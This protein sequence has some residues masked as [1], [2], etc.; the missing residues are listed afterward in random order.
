MNS[1]PPT[2][3]LA[4]PGSIPVVRHARYSA[5][6][7]CGPTLFSLPAPLF[8]FPAEAAFSDQQ[9]VSIAV[10]FVEALAAVRALKVVIALSTR[11]VSVGRSKD[12][13]PM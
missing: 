7:I 1:V 9:P 3:L 8:L 6:R 5:H 12:K 11:A 4:A 13:I 2:A 10:F